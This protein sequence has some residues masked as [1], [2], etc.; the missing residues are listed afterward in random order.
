MCPPRF[1]WV[2]CQLDMLRGC[3][4]PSLRDA[5][6]ELPE[7]LDETYKRILLGI[8]KKKQEYVH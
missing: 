4:P 3:C 6:N 7:T 1:R 8:D 5:L 2:V